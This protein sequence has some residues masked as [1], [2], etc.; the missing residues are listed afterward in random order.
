MVKKISRKETLKSSRQKWILTI[1][2]W[3]ILISS[4]IS[5]LSDS[6]LSKVNMLVA[7]IVLAFIIV[8]GIIFDIIGIAVTT[9]D[10]T[11]FH[12][13]ASKKIHGAKIA[14]KLLRNADK[15]AT[16]CNDVVG[17]I[18]GI[19]SGSVGF[20]ITQKIMHDFINL[21]STAVNVGIG[22]IIASITICGKSIGKT[23]ALENNNEIVSRVSGF[24]YLIV[25][26]R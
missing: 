3:S 18:S 24:L 7:F 15:V 10:E 5:F 19:V 21:N 23:Y 4:S 8:T 1:L 20:F 12:A 11:P 6:L 2:I 22:A 25:K 17:D 9:A 14:I 26:D 16:F 13:M